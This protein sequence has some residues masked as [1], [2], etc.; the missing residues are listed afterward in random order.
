MAGGTFGRIA[1]GSRKDVSILRYNG[2]MEWDLPSP[3]ITT[4]FHGFGNG[5][6]GHPEQDRALSIREGALLQTF[7]RDY[8]FV[9]PGEPIR[10]TT[11]GR[12]I[13]NAVPVML[14]RAVAR[15][16]RTALGGAL[17]VMPDPI[18]RMRLSLNVL[19]HLGLNLYGNVP[20]V[21][22]EVVANAWNADA[23][24]VRVTLDPDA[25]TIMIQDDGIGMTREDINKRFFQA[26]T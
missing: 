20:A 21:L 22:S 10:I 24:T 4:Q 26:F 1:I 19:E 8:A 3:T 16:V 2:R 25:E 17:L 14:A 7:P 5:R 11:M 12:M 6:F 13:G 9:R 15:A 18:Y 23:R